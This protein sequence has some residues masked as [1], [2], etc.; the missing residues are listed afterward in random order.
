ME[1]EQKRDECQRK[2]NQVTEDL[3]KQKK[4]LESLPVSNGAGF[5]KR[6]CCE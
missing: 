6:D 3:V 2:F 5:T 1:L 4:E